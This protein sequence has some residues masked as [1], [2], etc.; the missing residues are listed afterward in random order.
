[1]AKT[2]LWQKTLSLA[3]LKVNNKQQNIVSQAARRKHREEQ[4]NFRFWCSL[5]G[6]S[7]A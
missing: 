5:Q 1:M 7:I 2:D 6:K 4:R 3:K